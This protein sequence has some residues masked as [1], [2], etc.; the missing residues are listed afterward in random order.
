MQFH[1][2]VWSRCEWA[3][4]PV[5]LCLFESLHFPSLPQD[6]LGDLTEFLDTELGQQSLE[7]TQLNF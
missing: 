1:K 6:T 5:N 3:Q 4:D 2:K 7:I